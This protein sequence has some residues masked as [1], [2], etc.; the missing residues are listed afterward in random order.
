MANTDTSVFV[1]TGALS[2]W[3]SRMSLLNEQSIESLNSFMRDVES[4]SEPWA[5]NS[6]ESFMGFGTELLNNA[7][8][9]HESMKQVDKFLLT[10]IETMEKE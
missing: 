6:A 9:C 3:S 4:L 1:E 2:G 7:L 10:V 5:G 8:S